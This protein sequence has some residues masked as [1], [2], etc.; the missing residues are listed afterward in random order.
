[1][2]CNNA[3][4][5]GHVQR[6]QALAE[7]ATIKWDIVLFSETR[8]EDADEL[9]GR[10]HRL[11]CSRGNLRWAGVAIFLHSFALPISAVH[12]KHMYCIGE[13]VLR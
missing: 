6:A 4:L 13:N 10:D 5:N 1:M 7:G 3:R 8:V 12:S 9:L 2:L 11:I